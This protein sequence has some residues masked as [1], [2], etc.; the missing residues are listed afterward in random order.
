MTVFKNL[1]IRLPLILL[2]G[3][4]LSLVSNG[5]SQYG[6]PVQR[7][8]QD[9]E[10]MLKFLHHTGQYPHHDSVLVLFDRTD[11]SGAGIV[12]GVFAM[13]SSHR[14]RVSP[15]PAGRYFVMIQ[16][17]GM[18]H[19]YWE[20]TTWVRHSKHRVLKI[21]LDPCEE[22][23]PGRSFTPARQPNLEKLIMATIRA[24]GGSRQRRSFRVY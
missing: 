3:S 5:Y 21:Y 8:H 17:L 7:S 23:I 12:A 10:M 4:G 13:D 16:C 15:I 11:R 2:L 20:T 18:H 1:L 22:Y 6:K 14:I 19:D 9:G 24:N